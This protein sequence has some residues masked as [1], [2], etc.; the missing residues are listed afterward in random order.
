[1]KIGL[2]GAT[3]FV[4]QCFLKQYAADHEVTCLCIEPDPVGFYEHPNVHYLHSDFS[5]E[6]IE[7]AFRGCDA[8]IHL[9]GLLS[10]KEREAWFMNYEPNITLA[11]KVFIAADRLGIRNIVNVS[12]RTV[13]DQ[14]C[15]TPHRETDL[16][17]PLNAYAVA[18]LTVEYLAD[19]YHSRCDLNVKTL[20]FAQIYGPGGRN[21]YM[22]EVFRENCEK[23]KPLTVFDR[24]GKELLYVKD[25][26]AALL[27]AAKNPS[28]HGIFNIGTGTFHT[29]LEIAESFCRV[30]ENGAGTI[31]QGKEDEPLRT[32][33]MDVSK[34][35]EVL[36]FKARY[37]LI[38]ALR[39]MKG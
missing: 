8:I 28:L 15:Q 3:G 19:L 9:A 37:D 35:E 30:Y 7:D 16:P 6:E 25:A 33:R 10:T 32:S 26:A 12:S 4:G 23:R 17:H 2:T 27:C 18:K 11:E 38:S 29:N 22:M 21:G 39:E 36:G 34:A 31:F 20:R 5:V 13:Y 24:Q 1:M 14:A